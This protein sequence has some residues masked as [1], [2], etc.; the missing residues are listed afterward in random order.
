MNATTKRTHGL[1]P[2]VV[3]LTAAGLTM[4]MG[5]GC[6]TSEGGDVAAGAGIGALLGAGIGAIAGGEKGALI[7][8]AAGAGAG[9]G[10]GGY[11][12]HKR[13]KLSKEQYEIQWAT[14]KAEEGLARLETQ[15]DELDADIKSLD[16]EIDTLES[17]R[18]ADRLSAAE[19]KDLIE[20]L[21]RKTAAAA[22][23]AAQVEK[24]IVDLR[25]SL[26][27]NESAETVDPEEVARLKEE[28]DRLKEVYAMERQRF[29][30]LTA[31]TDRA[32][33]I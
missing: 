1:K 17:R 30:T 7:G 15:R 14:A 19:K 28:L 13:K 23:R 22:A 5:G 12:A 2:T 16:R 33:G 25:A 20:D 32:A 31:M 18:A 26:A 21:D 3:L 10:V 24:S 27:D 29:D 9:A 6:A 8:A 11:A 4:G